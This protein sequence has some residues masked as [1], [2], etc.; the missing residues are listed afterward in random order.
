MAPAKK[1]K[2]VNVVGTPTFR[3]KLKCKLKK[4]TTIDSYDLTEI[5]G[6]ESTNNSFAAV[7]GYEKL[8]MSDLECLK[9]PAGWLND[10][11]IN[12]RQIPLQKKFPNV[13]GFQ[14]VCLG[15]AQSFVQQKGP[16]VQILNVDDSH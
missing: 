9:S 5:E 16:F 6:E 7:I 14:N 3:A 12:A 15:R 8:I 13:H 1:L 11:L 2:Q 4:S 10:R